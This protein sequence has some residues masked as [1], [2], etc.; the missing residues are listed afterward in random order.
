MQRLLI[1]VLAFSMLI[2]AAPDFAAD[3]AK[4]A[5]THTPAA[6]DAKEQKSISHGSVTV[7]GQTIK[8]T[9][10]AGTIIL[11][12]DKGDQTA[13]MFY[14]AYTKD[15]TKSDK[16]PLTFAYNG[17]PGGS[18]VLVNIGGFGPMRV[19]TTDAAPTPPPPY[20]L[21]NNPYSLLDKSDLVFIDAVGT[22]FSKLLGKATDKDFWGTD[23]DV[24]S[25]GEFIVNYITENNRWNSPKFILGE[26]Y[27]T[28]RSTMLANWLQDKGVALNGVILL[29]SILNF[30]NEFWFQPPGSNDL[31]YE[32]YLPSYAA[33][34]WYHNAL[35]NKPA[36]LTAFLVQVRQFAVGDYADAL[37]AGDSITSTQEAS[38]LQ[39]LH[40]YT[41]L[42]ET[43]LKETKLRIEPAR[44]M[45]Q[46]LRNQGR[47]VGRY[48]ARYEGIDFDSAGEFPGYDPS[49]TAMFPAV[50]TAFHW[51]LSNDL[52]FNSDADY[53]FLNYRVG[54]AWDWHH[55]VDGQKYPVPDTL[56]D[57]RD[58]MTQNPHLMVFSGNGYFDLA[59]PFFKT[60]Y[61]LNHMGLAPALQKNITLDYYPDGHML[62]INTA[63]LAKLHADLDKFYDSALAK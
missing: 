21:E 26:S 35:P 56:P 25:F 2:A 4:S 12:N 1:C 10:T 33:V 54:R 36:D 51:Y 32:L 57:L 49:G 8:Y 13:S 50:V 34:A 39:K 38:V 16:R 17:G 30:N 14:I 5:T 47:T 24:Q 42:S 15:G 29:S 37:Q 53:E 58:A 62:Y 60:E 28:P 46:L 61:E 3:M 9:A 7:N 40:A 55:T 45:K 27:G 19:Q 52:K 41:G 18:S 63:A 22:G 11:K 20:T 31:S 48:D 59:T 6:A 23:P 44:F 43:Y